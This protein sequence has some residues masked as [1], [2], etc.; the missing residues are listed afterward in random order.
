MLRRMLPTSWWSRSLWIVT[1]YVIAADLLPN[2]V[3]VLVNCAGYLPYSDRPGPGWQMPHLPT[4]DELRFFAGF[5]SRLLG[6]TAFY[7]LIFAAAGLVLGFCL[8]PRWALRV[9]AAPTAFPK[10]RIVMG[11]GGRVI[12]KCSLG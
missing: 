4:G 6:A 10:R 8:L 2:L 3:L 5:A 7:G 12:D 1:T 11:A 9:L